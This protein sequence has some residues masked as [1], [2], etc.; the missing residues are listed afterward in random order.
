[1]P[2]F[3]LF[4]IVGVVAAPALSSADIR[5]TGLMHIARANHASVVLVD[6][7]VLVVGG[8]AAENGCELVPG[9]LY[10]PASGEWSL[11][12]LPPLAIDAKFNPTTLADG[13]IEVF[14]KRRCTESRQRSVAFDPKTSTWRL[15]EES[16]KVEGNVTH[17]E[18]SPELLRRM[19]GRRGYSTTTL[20]N[21]YVLIAGG[22][23]SNRRVRNAELFLPELEYDLI[24]TVARH[25]GGFAGRPIGVASTPNG[26]VFVS[27]CA[28]AARCARTQLFEWSAPVRPDVGPVK[29][30]TV[31]RL[32]IREVASELDG[33]THAVRI[34]A[35]GNI[36]V[37]NQGT[38]VIVKMNRDGKPTQGFFRAPS[39]TGTTNAIGAALPAE[40]VFRRPTDI[41]WDSEGNL[42][43]ADAGKAQVIKYSSTGVF[44]KAIG[45][46]HSAPYGLNN[47]HSIVA[48]RTGN[49]YVANHGDSNIKV[50]D[51]ELNLRGVYEGVGKPF[52]LCM[53]Q[54]TPQYLYSSSNAEKNIENGTE[55]PGEIYKMDLHGKVIGRIGSYDGST[56]AFRTPHA[57]DCTVEQQVVVVTGA[58]SFVVSLR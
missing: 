51:A 18:T 14:A 33:M 30:N 47:P 22:T 45:A 54:G 42:F 1:V 56:D 57:I 35:T 37:V 20:K 38:N 41:A 55:N 7:R 4:L 25:G 13:E 34:D 12:P 44:L 17:I 58:S 49:L 43:V 31:M 24:R 5:S 28:P 19:A 2:K 48:D 11:T 6:G 46:P 8:S 3:I 16:S 40:Y 23:A 27:E 29:G 50:F 9:E 32:L 52:G 21:G 39:E 10:D 26:H 53:S 15:V 36:W